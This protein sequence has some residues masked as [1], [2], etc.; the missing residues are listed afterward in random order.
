MKSDEWS[1]TSCEQRF[2]SPAFRTN[3]GLGRLLWTCG[4]SLDG[5]NG[6]AGL[7]MLRIYMEA[8]SLSLSLSLYLVVRFRLGS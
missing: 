7:L 3:K 6:L 8:L 2:I 4:R 1:V 5:L